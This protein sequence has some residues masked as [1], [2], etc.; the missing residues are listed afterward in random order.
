MHEPGWLTFYTAAREIEQRFGGSQA[1]A[2]AKLREACA[3]QWIRSIKAPIEEQ[4][5]LPIE[6]WTRVAPSEWRE[7]EVDYDGPDADGCEIEAMINESDFRYWLDGRQGP[8]ANR[9]THKRDLA[10]QAINALWPNGIPKSLLNKQIEKQVGNWLKE[11]GF[12]PIS[13]DTILRAAGFKS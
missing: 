3:D 6:F 2:Q 11:Q 9:P 5:R 10:Q 12:P 7:R 4:G 13:R 8:A 1:E